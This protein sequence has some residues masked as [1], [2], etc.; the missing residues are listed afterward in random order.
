MLKIFLSIISIV[1]VLNASDYSRSNNAAKEAFKNLDCDFGDCPKPAPEPK[2][3]IQEKVIVKEVPVV[4]EKVI[5]KDRAV[6]V[7]D[8]SS[9]EE[10]KTLQNKIYNKAFFDINLANTEPI[11]D[12]ITYSKRRAFD[13]VN[14][15][16][17]VNKVKAHLTAVIEGNIEIP[18]TITTQK[19]Y[20]N[21]GSKYQHSGAYGDP[22]KYI[23]YNGDNR[24]NKE[25][26]LVDAQ[27][28]K[29][30]KRYVSYKIKV[31]VSK[32]HT[33]STN[34]RATPNDII[35]KIAPYERGYKNKFILSEIYIQ[36]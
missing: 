24:Q 10:P 22:T 28:D 30:G 17:S 12:Y 14:F 15:V 9:N 26:F 23:Y 20:V 18:N 33:L 31:F 2:V 4:V 29:D 7:E 5:Y 35:F 3:I 21:V 11:Q 16:D 32:Y 6:Q 1:L 8:K 34:S 13:V 25:Y 19:V 27:V 36:E